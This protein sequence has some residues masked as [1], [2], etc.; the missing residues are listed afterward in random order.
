VNEF[1]MELRRMGRNDKEWDKPGGRERVTKVLLTTLR[2]IMAGA[3][4]KSMAKSILRMGFV[5]VAAVG[6]FFAEG[7]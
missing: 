1:G 7:W 5:L 2:C 6:V 4:L 3:L